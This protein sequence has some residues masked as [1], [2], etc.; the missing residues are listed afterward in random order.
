MKFITVIVLVF[1]SLTIFGNKIDSLDTKKNSIQ[2]QPTD[3]KISI[4]QTIH[5]EDITE[6][7]DTTMSLDK[8]MPWI[9][10]LLIGFSAAFV[11]FW[12]AH[13][14]RQSNERNLQRQIEN[15][16]ETT[17]TQFNATLATKNRQDWI[18]ELRQ[19]LSEFLTYSMCLTPSFV[20]LEPEEHKKYLEK[21]AFTK[22]KIELL[23]NVDKQEQI[24]LLVALDNVLEVLSK[25]KGDFNKEEM[26]LARSKT[27]SAARKLFRIHWKKIK[28]LK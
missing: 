11:N 9:A 28:L 19:T 24:E 10:A 13:R 5:I 12:V 20:P 15:S 25:G 16:K 18:N 22:S 3:V 23:I 21:L 2:S 26:Q 7:S 1:F 14:L 17:L 4:P 27:I 6:K 8:N